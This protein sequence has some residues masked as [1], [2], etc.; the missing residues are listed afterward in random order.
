MFQL[1]FNLNTTHDSVG[2]AL[3]TANQARVT[4]NYHALLFSFYPGL[5]LIKLLKY[6]ARPTI[7][8]SVPRLLNRIHDKV[9]LLLFATKLIH[10]KELCNFLTVFN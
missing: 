4:V 2:K 6:F 9:G 10:S 5:T 7:F 8:I 3:R 1:C